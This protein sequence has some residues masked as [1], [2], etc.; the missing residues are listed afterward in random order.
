MRDSGRDKGHG[1]GTDFLPVAICFR[2]AS[3]RKHVN[4]FFL[5]GMY[6]KFVLIA[7]KIFGDIDFNL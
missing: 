6:M 5:R 3:S 7:G 1:D 2:H 4:D